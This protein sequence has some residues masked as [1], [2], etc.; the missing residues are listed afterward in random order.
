MK[1][2]KKK[3]IM[4]NEPFI[5]VGSLASYVATRESSCALLSDSVMFCLV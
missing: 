5:G 2:K 1:K 3:K 4:N